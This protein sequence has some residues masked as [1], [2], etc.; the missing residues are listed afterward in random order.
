MARLI[1][2]V[3][4]HAPIGEFRKRFFP[5]EVTHCTCHLYLYSGLPGALEQSRAH[6]FNDCP[7]AHT[8]CPGHMDHW[9]THSWEVNPYPNIA[10]WLINHPYAFSFAL[11]HKSGY[12]FACDF[13]FS[14]HGREHEEYNFECARCAVNHSHEHEPGSHPYLCQWCST[15]RAAEVRALIDSEEAGI[16]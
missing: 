14:E 15:I 13:C 11:S 3:S 8:E 9:A 5:N 4:L 7:H 6:V 2:M 12:D 1:R 10:Q 16:G